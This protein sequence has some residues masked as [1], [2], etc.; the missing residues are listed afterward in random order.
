MFDFKAFSISLVIGIVIAAWQPLAAQTEPSGNDSTIFSLFGEDEPLQLELTFDIKRFIKRKYKDEYQNA[1]LKVFMADSS[2]VSDTIRIKARGNF[3]KGYCQ[4]PPI[5]LNFKK[6]DF[7]IEDLK[8]LEKVKLVTTCRYQNAFQQYL[9]QEHLI[10]K[11][12]NLLTDKSFQVRLVHITYHD[13]E[14]KKKTFSQYGFLIEEVDQM[15][16]RNDC[17][18]IETEGVSGRSC[19]PYSTTLMTVF[20]YMIGN[21]DYLINNLHNVK[22]IR[23]NN[24][25]Q[26]V[27]FPV[28][29]DFDYSGMVNT[30]YAIPHT[31]LGIESVRER[32]YRGYRFPNEIYQQV[33]GL[34]QS[35]RSDIYELYENYPY[36]DKK[37]RRA[38][39]SYLDEFYKILDNPPSI[40]RKIL[41]ASN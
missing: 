27:V 19:D 4:F 15:A 10:Y 32:L 3:R 1:S 20:E 12:Y 33:F 5:R 11:A 28:P 40:K 18:E 17:F 22:L 9:F 31:D 36:F 14:G 30:L 29:Y 6:A 39:I 21:T 23:P 13:S 8:K 34:F 16:D 25:L 35:K 41:D 2:Y 38:S 24:P 37:T 26:Q 7:E